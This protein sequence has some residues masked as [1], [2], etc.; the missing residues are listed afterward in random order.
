[1]TTE[2]IIQI[3]R[4]HLADNGYSGLRQ[5]DAECGCELD[6]LNPCGDSFAECKPGYRHADP[7]PGQEDG[8]AIFPSWVTPKPEE[9]EGIET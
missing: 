3:V 4:K 2:T 8:W 7:R 9:W 1:M 6:D 5:P